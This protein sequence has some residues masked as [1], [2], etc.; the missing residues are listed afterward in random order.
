[1]T[2]E[3]AVQQKTHKLFVFL[4]I[5]KKGC[6]FWRAM[7]ASNIQFHPCSH[8][9]KYVYSLRPVVS[10]RSYT[11]RDVRDA[12][13]RTSSFPKSILTDH[14][15]VLRN[16]GE[17]RKRAWGSE[18]KREKEKG[19]EPKQWERKA[20]R[21]HRDEEWRKRKERLLLPCDRLCFRWLLVDESWNAWRGPVVSFQC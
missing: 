18:K 2:T 12:T 16:K 10:M 20:M 15:P 1:M 3:I 9:R 4:R 11:S 14:T 6:I 5:Q 7:N 13:T 21:T 19:E 8:V 17:V